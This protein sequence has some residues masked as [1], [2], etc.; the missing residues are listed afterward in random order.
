MLDVRVVSG[1]RVSPVSPRR[2]SP[3]SAVRVTAVSGRVSLRVPAQVPSDGAGR[4]ES[5]RLGHVVLVHAL[6]TVLP[7]DGRVDGRQLEAHGVLEPDRLGQRGAPQLQ[8][9]HL[10]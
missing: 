10:Q 9:R 3:V 2:V 8:S 5:D 6:V 1:A 7:Q 4:G